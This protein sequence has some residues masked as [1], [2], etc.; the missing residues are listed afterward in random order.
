[1]REFPHAHAEIVAHDSAVRSSGFSA[2]S[3]ATISA[4]A[5]GNSRIYDWLAAQP[6]VDPSKI[7]IMGHSRGGKTALWTGASDPRFALVYS[8]QSG[9]GGAKLNH[10]KLPQSEHIKQIL[11]NFPYW[12]CGNYAKYINKEM[13]MPFDQHMLAALIAPRPLLI[14]SATLDMWCGQ[15]GEWWTAHLASP[16]W[17]LYGKKGLVAEAYP[18]PESPQMDGSVA[19]FVRTGIHSVTV[20]EWDRVMEFAEKQGWKGVK[21]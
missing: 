17:E 20:Y 3:W 19:Y 18:A 4:W 16:A 6:E 13:S 12:F 8:I 5:W 2:E 1:M 7:A 9:C 10:V 14:S 15:E 21:R 11:K